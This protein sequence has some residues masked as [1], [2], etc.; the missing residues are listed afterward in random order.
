[1]LLLCL[2]RPAECIAPATLAR[3][4]F[5]AGGIA[6]VEAPATGDSPDLGGFDPERTPFV[7][8][9]AGSPDP[10]DRAMALA[11][12]LRDRGAK[13]VYLAGGEAEGFDA[14][15]R[16]EMDALALLEDAW[17]ALGEMPG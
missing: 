12:G 4:L 9:C 1:V 13:R 6:A 16:E 11:R 7:V 17:R 8:L 14:V 10:G 2:G 15:L 3:N 5:E